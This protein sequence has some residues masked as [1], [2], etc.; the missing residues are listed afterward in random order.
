MTW[1]STVPVTGTNI[2]DISVIFPDN[3]HAFEEILSDQ[4]YIFSNELSGRHIAGKTALL[5]SDATTGITG[6]TPPGSGALGFDTTLGSL[7]SYLNSSWTWVVSFPTTRILS[8]MGSG[9]GNQSLAPSGTRIRFDTESVDTLSEFNTTTYT[10]TPAASGFFLATATVSVISGQA[11]ITVYLGMRHT[12]SSDEQKN[13]ARTSYVI[14]DTN[15]V[16]LPISLILKVAAGDKIYI[17]VSH[18][19]TTNII[20]ECDS[21]RTFLQI[22]RLS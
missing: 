1:R 10:F 6:M 8:Y 4:H 21:D 11:G 16:S 13:H 3:W 17:D 18:T 22:K 9:G 7:M 12:N 20:A 2:L 15:R 5:C 19:S 14:L